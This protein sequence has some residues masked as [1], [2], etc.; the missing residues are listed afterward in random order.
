MQTVS[1]E[2]IPSS[3][4]LVFIM[5]G[6]PLKQ[7]PPG[8]AYTVISIS[9]LQFILEVIT[10]VFWSHNWTCHGFATQWGK[11]AITHLSAPGAPFHAA[12][13]AR[14]TFSVILSWFST[15]LLSAS[16]QSFPE[17]SPPWTSVSLRI[18]P[19]E[20]LSSL[21]SPSW[22]DPINHR[23]QLHLQL[24]VDVFYLDRLCFPT[25]CFFCL[26]CHLFLVNLKNSLSIFKT[27]FKENF[28]MALLSS[29]QPSFPKPWHN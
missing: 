9:S 24:W 14:A 18:L 22:R 26:G 4:H 10:T 21:A 5:V 11:S 13:P 27:Q 1:V 15:Y 20:L 25:P 2:C 19:C 12:S 7:P 28:Q 16:F 6:F 29:L 23:L 8:A 3:Y 17:F